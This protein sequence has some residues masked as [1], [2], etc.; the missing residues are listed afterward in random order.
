[1]RSPTEPGRLIGVG[2]GPGDPE[3]LT[4][5][6]VAA[7]R[8]AP[9]VAFFAKE[10]RRG[11][12]RQIADR[13]IPAGC[14]EL[15]LY[16]PLTT[17]MHFGMPAYV[18]TLQSFYEKAADA[19][20]GHLESGRDVAL[21]AEGDPLFYG[22]F[23]HL[24]I[25]LRDRFAT[26]IIPGVTGMT[27]CWGVAGEPMTWGDDVLTV[28]PGTL[29]EDELATRLAASDAAIIMKIG[30]NFPK[31]R[32]AIVKAGLLARAIYVERGTMPGEVVVRLADKA[33]DD[34]PYFSLILVPGGGRRP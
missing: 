31:V 27:G 6:A 14:I 18:S 33:G 7:I 26:A 8:A 1:V 10:G 34:A 28:L 3:L 29:P 5:K 23:M 20:A 32:A 13:W 9:V 24:Y 22:S 30:R 11:H 12:A 15:P 17:E 16:Y 4:V 2:L 21:L 19:L 25:R